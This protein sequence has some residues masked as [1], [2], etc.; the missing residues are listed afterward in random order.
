MW[1]YAIC[2]KIEVFPSTLNLKLY[3]HP[4]EI[5]MSFYA[6]KYWFFQQKKRHF[7]TFM[8]YMIPLSIVSDPQRQNVKCPSL[9]H[10]NHQKSILFSEIFN[11]F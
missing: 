3:I 8:V 10:T 9:H 7:S 2:P 5:Q 4:T 11:L 6:V 1:M